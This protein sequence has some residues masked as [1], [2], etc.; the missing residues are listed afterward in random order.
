M[1]SDGILRLVTALGVLASTASATVVAV[2]RSSPLA[3]F[4]TAT[5]AIRETLVAAPG[6]PE[7][8]TFDLEGERDR[9]PAVLEDAHDA[10]P[11]VFVSV[12]SLATSALLDDPRARPLVFSMVLYP[13]QSGFLRERRAQ[14]VTGSSLDVPLDVQFAYLRRLLPEARR[15]G[16]LYS[17]DETGALVAAAERAATAAGLTLTAQPLVGRGNPVELLDGLAGKV[18][19]LWGV[20]DSRIFTPQTTGPLILASLR[21]R[22]PFI[23]LSSAQVRAGALAALSCDYADVGRQ[24]ADLVLRVL[25]G[26]AAGT[27]AVTTPRRVSLALN[28]RSAAHLGVT[29]PAAVEADVS[30][31]V[32]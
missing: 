31:R 29:I 21:R 20:A 27:L 6:Q 9:A 12:G 1:R 22:L 8:L 4:E 5:T 10:H 26:A 30:E 7:V 18:D 19:V 15:V 16:V 3:P 14:Q 17:P 24:T 11:A 32:Q 28:L 23:G 13:E 2:V 25:A